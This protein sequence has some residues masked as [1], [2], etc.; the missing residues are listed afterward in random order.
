MSHVAHVIVFVIVFAGA[1]E[2]P[3]TARLFGFSTSVTD[4]IDSLDLVCP[5]D[6]SPKKL[7]E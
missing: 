3:K 6:A 5:L 2:S 1:L 7:S 4:H